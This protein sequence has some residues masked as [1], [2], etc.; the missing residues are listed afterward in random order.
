MA[1]IILLLS[2]VLNGIFAM[3]EIAMV[4]SRKARLQQRAEKGELGAEVALELLL[5]PNRFL[6]TIQIG[7]TLV[8]IF[9][10]A[11]GAA[12]LAEPIGDLFENIEFIRPFAD[13]VAFVIVVLV[14]T[15]FSLIIGE[16]VPKRV[17]LNN[18]EAVSAALAIPMRFISTLA[19]PFVSFLSASSEFGIK[20]LGIK[21]NSEP[22]ISEEEIIVMIEQGRQIGVFEKAERDMV[23]SVFRLGERR[24]EAL[25]TP[26]MEM[27]WLD[28]N[29]PNETI[30]QQ[31]FES[32]HSRI[33]VADGDLDNIIGYLQVRELI[34]YS[35]EDPDFNLRDF[36]KH[37]IY[38]PE[39]MPALKALDNIQTSGIHLA[40]VVDE[41]GGIIGMITDYDILEAIVGEI[42]E[43][44]TDTDNLIVQREDGSWLL[45]GLIVIDQLKELIGI[46]D[47][48]GEDHSDFQTLSGFVMSQL[49]R[50]PK[51]SAKF[52]YE[53]FE[54][55][56]VDMDGRRVDR[57]LVSRIK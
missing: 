5:K 36:I 16:L 53:D 31:I 11:F 38:L 21:P 51:I 55:E 52:Q 49:G 24:V 35:H 43:D 14:I 50:I 26:R 18:P 44:S 57:V 1:I 10:G 3:A 2:M 7:I 42:P 20:L 33:P 34:K 12:Q 25:M 29:S 56:V 45:D 22:D 39:N 30:W 32:P 54:F 46:S 40:M 37:P 17:A 4:S 47:L 19:G 6:S 13:T 15:Y 27:I 48:P 9:S 41:F 28:V 8:G 23:S